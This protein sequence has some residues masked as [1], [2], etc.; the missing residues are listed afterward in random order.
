VHTF[1]GILS[2]TIPVSIALFPGLHEIPWGDIAA[3]SVVVT[4]PLIILVFAF[5]R[6]IIEGLTAGAVKG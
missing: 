3:A 5:Q 4:I 6:R 1:S 2:R